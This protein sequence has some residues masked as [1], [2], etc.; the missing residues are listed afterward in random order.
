MQKKNGN[1]VGDQ[2]FVKPFLKHQTIGE[3]TACSR[4]TVNTILTNLRK[5]GIIDFDRSKLVINNIRKL[6]NVVE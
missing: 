1:Q 2:I 5:E 6:K 3:L 4:Q